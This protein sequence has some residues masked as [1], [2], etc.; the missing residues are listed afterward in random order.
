MSRLGTE[1][2]FE[3]LARARALEARGRHVIHLEI[4]EPDFDTP[5]FI[6]EAAVRALDEGYT[7]YTPAAG[8]PQAREAI[9][10]YVSRTR[11]FSV[12]PSEVVITPGGKPVMSFAILALVD[13][14]EEVIYPNP[15]FPIYE[16]MIRWVGAVPRPLPL[17]EEHDF[18]ADPDELRSLVTPKTRMLIM[19]SPH[20]PCGSVLLREDLAAIAEICAERDIYVLS[21][22]IYSR[23]LYDAEHVSIAT[24][25]GMR[26]RTIILDGF[27]KTY[28]MTGWR[29][30]YGVMSREI[31]QAVTQLMINVN[32]CTAAFTQIAGI[33]ALEGPQD[34]VDSMV[35]EFRRRRDA[36]VAGL[37]AI[38]GITCRTP[39]GAFYAFPNVTALD[40]DGKRFADYLLEEAGVA[41]LAGTAFGE[42]GR[43]YLR[44]SYANSLADIEEALRR[45]TGA[46]KAFPSAVRV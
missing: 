34:E 20:N 40:P 26:E 27:S 38:D 44:I 45:I 23:I 37:N 18:R 2:A 3:V 13:P 46:A 6:K 41:V 43:G 14:G 19:N 22:E 17:R 15:G 25:P 8:M 5:R 10:R 21:D 9:A 42:Y 30:G 35:R 28:A 31:A 32:S 24:L 33:A 39:A 16:S 29:L 7:H 11:G 1:T 36:I 12:D 4:G